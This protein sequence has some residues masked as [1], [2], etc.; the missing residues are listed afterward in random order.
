MKPGRQIQPA[1]LQT[2]NYDAVNADIDG[3]DTKMGI[4]FVCFLFHS[5]FFCENQG[6]FST[7]LAEI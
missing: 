4:R 5:F 7:R 3:S 2:P 1:V 6:I